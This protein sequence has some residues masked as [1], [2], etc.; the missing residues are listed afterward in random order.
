MQGPDTDAQD[1]PPPFT[2]IQLATHGRSIQLG[3]T[4]KFGCSP[5]RSALPSITDIVSSGWQ[6]RFVPISEVN[7]V[8]RSLRRRARARKAER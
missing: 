5:G 7:E 3:Q 1:Q 6:V 4:E 8:I 2:Q